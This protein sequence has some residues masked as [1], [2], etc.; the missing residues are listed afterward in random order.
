MLYKVETASITAAASGV[1]TTTP[2][3]VTVNPGAASNFV[4]AGGSTQIAGTTNNLTITAKDTYGNTA[5]SYNGDKDLTFS[6]ANSI[7][8]YIP[9]V[10]RKNNSAVNFGSATTITFTNGVSSAGGR[11]VLYKAE[12]ANIKATAG[13]VNTPTELSVLVSPANIDH[14]YVSTI[15]SPKTHNVAFPVTIKAQDLYTNDITSGSEQVNITAKS[16][17]PSPTNVTTVNGTLTFDVTLFA[18]PKNNQQLTFTGV[19]SGVIGKSNNF[20]VN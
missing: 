1:I 20:D 9:T 7:G 5:T 18:Y 19:T 17:T 12:T 8:S 4:I 10:T 2:L 14:Y 6:G 16:D 3:S 13:A 11:M 15:T